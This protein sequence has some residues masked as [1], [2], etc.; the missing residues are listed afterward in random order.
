MITKTFKCLKMQEDGKNKYLIFI[1]YKDLIEIT[2]VG[3]LS[4]NRIVDEEKAKKMVGFIRNEEKFYPTLLMVTNENCSTKYNSLE[5]ELTIKSK[6]GKCLGVVDGQ[7]R[8]KS[9][10]L[11]L[12][13][14]DI[15]IEEIKKLGNKEQA[16]FLIDN[17]GAQ[18]QRELFLEI[19]STPSKVKKG[20]QLRLMITVCNHYGLKYL[21][22]KNEYL[23]YIYFDEDQVLKK[24]EVKIPYKFV[25]KAH[26]KLFKDFEKKYLNNMIDE[27]LINTYYESVE[28]I[29]NVIFE[30]I[31]K[32]EEN[33]KKSIF[34]LEIFY[35]SLFQCIYQTIVSK[36]LE[37]NNQTIKE[38]F[39]KIKLIF[40]IDAIEFK[41]EIDNVPVS[42]KKIEII[43]NKIEEL[44]N[45]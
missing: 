37:F 14:K 25:L 7:H 33:F 20:T 21:E 10:E 32:Y 22:R 41:T 36:E 12:S 38:L 15:P 29:W 43:K 6:D 4:V 26:E 5:N 13:N 18:E 44:L 11:M 31:R 19:N 42:G 24:G 9:I 1:R 39:D 3:K 2:E 45:K 35:T 40:D 8:Y 30:N 17:L 16:V 28:Y 27:N 34:I 23:K